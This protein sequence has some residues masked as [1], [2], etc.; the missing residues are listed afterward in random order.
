MTALT[1]NV[2]HAIECEDTACVALEFA[3][4]GL[5]MLQVTT[6]AA[7]NQP[8]MITVQGTEGSAVARGEELDRERPARRGAP[9]KHQ[10]HK[11]LVRPHQVQFEA[12]FGALANGERP[13][14]AGDESRETLAAT[15]AMYESARRGVAIRVPESRHL[16]GS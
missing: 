2:L 6:C 5:G 1:T 9:S 4:G 13:P 10:R 16:S 15:L 11:P 7:E 12:I 8:A 14:V 3:R